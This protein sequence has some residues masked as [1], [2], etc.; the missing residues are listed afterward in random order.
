MAGE[1]D[2]IRSAIAT[3]IS[4][5]STCSTAGLVQADA[6]TGAPMQPPHLR[7]LQVAGFDLIDRPNS[8]MERYRLTIPAEL[9]VGRP[10]GLARSNVVGVNIARAVQVEFQ[11]GVKLGGLVDDCWLDGWEAGLQDLVDEEADRRDMD[12]I[13][14]TFLADV[15]EYLSTARTA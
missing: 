6:L 5:S 13:R 15:T 12:G 11:S 8:R 1:Y 9:V 4:T 14:F 2:A 3:K 10:S 7:V